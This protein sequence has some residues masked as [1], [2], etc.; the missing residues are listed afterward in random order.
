VATSIGYRTLK[1]LRQ[2]RGLKENERKTKRASKESF[3]R[4]AEKGPELE[5]GGSADSKIG[6]GPKYAIECNFPKG[7]RKTGAKQ[8]LGR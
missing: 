7:Y 6:E 1:K 4:K 2:E 5:R 3:S 8:K